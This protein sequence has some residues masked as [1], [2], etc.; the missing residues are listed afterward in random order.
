MAAYDDFRRVLER[1]GYAFQYAV[2]G[3]AREL[4]EAQPTRSPWRHPIEE[5][6]VRVQGRAT[7]IDFLLSN[8]DWPALLVAECKRCEPGHRW[9]FARSPYGPQRRV[10]ETVYQLPE[11]SPDH[12]AMRI[13][14]E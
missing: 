7:H 3:R 10:F 6:P 2:L 4:A 9:G 13:G 8:T 1:H 12:A 14:V 11:I 5:F